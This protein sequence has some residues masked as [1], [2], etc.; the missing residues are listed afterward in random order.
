MKG[1]YDITIS[2]WRDSPYSLEKHADVTGKM[3]GFLGITRTYHALAKVTYRDLLTNHRLETND[4]LDM[5]DVAVGDLLIKA[6]DDQTN[7]RARFEAAAR[8]L[9]RWNASRWRKV[10][11]NMKPIA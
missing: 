3:S 9:V 6:H 8:D 11:D 7:Q 4:R 1:V 10:G 2:S 5:I